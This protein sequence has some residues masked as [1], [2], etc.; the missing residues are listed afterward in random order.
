MT[1]GGESLAVH[2]YILAQNPALAALLA[3]L[4]KQKKENVS[5]F[6]DLSSAR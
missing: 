2:R 6:P 1:V 3:D 5:P 4:A